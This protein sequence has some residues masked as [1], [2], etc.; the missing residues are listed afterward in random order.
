MHN[1]T[2]TLTPHVVTIQEEYVPAAE[3]SFR[4]AINDQLVIVLVFRHM[5]VSFL[6]AIQAL[7]FA[8]QALKSLG[9]H[10]DV[11]LKEESME[12]TCTDMIRKLRDKYFVIHD[13]QALFKE[14]NRTSHH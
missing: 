3:L 7:T 11:E 9:E 14:P 4:S 8:E 1:F 13:R 12:A 6:K 5:D 2:M 10:K